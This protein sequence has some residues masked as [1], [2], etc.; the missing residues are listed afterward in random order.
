M[1]YPVGKIASVLPLY[2][3]GSHVSLSPKIVFFMVNSVR[4]STWYNL[5]GAQG[6]VWVSMSTT[7]ISVW[8]QARYGLAILAWLS[9]SFGIF[10]VKLTSPCL[11]DILVMTNT[12]YWL[13]MWITYEMIIAKSLFHLTSSQKLSIQRS[14]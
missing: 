7:S 4:R 12:N 8:S 1:T 5:R 10:R 13:F 3:Q 2:L 9:N 11:K 14:Q 6:V